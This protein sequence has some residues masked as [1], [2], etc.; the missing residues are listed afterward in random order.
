MEKTWE[1]EVKE[2]HP[3][4]IETLQTLADRYCE[5]DPPFARMPTDEQKQI[6]AELVARMYS[7][8]SNGYA[9]LMDEYE[10]ELKAAGEAA[11]WM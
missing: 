2:M 6:V 10:A 1:E 7:A 5:D 11:R 8:L 9:E 3:D 4:L